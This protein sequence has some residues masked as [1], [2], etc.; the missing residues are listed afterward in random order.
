MLVVGAGGL[1]GQLFEDLVASNTQDVVFWSETEPRF[2]FIKE[3][4]KIISTDEQVKEY[5][6]TVTRSFIL[7][8]GDVETRKKI[9]EKFKNLGGKVTTFITPFC[10]ISKYGVTIGEG[11]MVLNKVNMESGVTI[12]KECLINKRSY[13]GHECVIHDHCEIGPTAIISAEAEIGE[14]SLVGIGA[15]VLPR[16][17]IGKNCLVAAGAVVTKNFGDNAVVSGVPAELRFYKKVKQPQE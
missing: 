8:V 11:S 16:I 15:I 9:S 1:A 3:R 7:C 2:D 12:G 4:F 13:Y 5:F 6:N 10:D 14:G 17:K